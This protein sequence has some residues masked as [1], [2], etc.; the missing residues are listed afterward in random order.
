MRDE[1]AERVRQLV[2]KKRKQGKDVVEAE[3]DA[4]EREATPEVDLLETIRRSLQH[5]NGARSNGRRRKRSDSDWQDKS[6][7]E[8]YKR[9]K[10][11][12]IPDRSK[13]NKQELIREISRAKS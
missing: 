10:K 2:D 9:A 3:R 4:E 7:D 5:G 6:K 8:L 1:Y 11:L 12:D 13:L